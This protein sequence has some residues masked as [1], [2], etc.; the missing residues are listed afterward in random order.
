MFNQNLTIAGLGTETVS[1]PA[2]GVYSLDGKIQL[3]RIVDGA[4][5][6]SSVVMTIVNGTG[7]VTVYTGPAGADGFKVDTICAAGDALTFTL[8]SANA[9][10]QGLNT[11]KT[12]V[13]VSSGV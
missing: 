2:A 7:P 8:S 1:I 13:A 11:I 5:D 9:V 4:A 3:P 10:D 12:V 6:A